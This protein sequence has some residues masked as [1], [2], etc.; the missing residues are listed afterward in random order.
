MTAEVV[1]LVKNLL[2]QPS[3]LRTEYQTL[4]ITVRITDKIIV[5]DS[6]KESPVMSTANGLKSSIS[7]SGSSTSNT[8][9]Q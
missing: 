7:G 6:S 8:Q 4:L 9:N 1:E 5:L 3:R 2:P